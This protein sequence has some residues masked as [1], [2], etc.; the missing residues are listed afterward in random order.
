MILGFVQGLTEFLPVSSSGHLVLFQNLFGLREPEL[1]LDIAL[2]MGT[3]LA[4]V[5]VFAREIGELFTA[6]V[7]LPRL[8]REAGGLTPLLA[9]NATVRLGMLIVVGSVPTAVIGLAL[10]DY[11]DRLFGSVALVGLML[12]ATGVLLLATRFLRGEE[13]SIFRVSGYHALW[14]GL[15][16]GL[17][18]TPGVSRSGATIATALL[19]GVNRDLAGRY[20]FLLSLPAILGA[21]VVGLDVDTISTSVPALAIGVGTLAAAVVGYAALKLLL[22]VVRQG[23]LYRFAPYCFVV[24]AL[25]FYLGH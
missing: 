8:W 12:C 5:V 14:I 24:G 15:A 22:A 23:H 25:A 7:Q 20:S 21:L 16:Q 1:L 2:H 13:R 3:L 10:K 18:I 11:A 6:L 17:A 19:L 9:S 4:V